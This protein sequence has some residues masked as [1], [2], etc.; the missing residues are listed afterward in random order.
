[1]I[2]GMPGLRLYGLRAADVGGWE[3][4]HV[5]VPHDRRRNAHHFAV[6]ERCRRPPEAVALKDI[7]VAPVA[8]CV[9]D[10][11]R[12]V[13]EPDVVRELVAETIQRGMCSVADLIREIH[14]S[15]RQRTALTR[16]ALAQID[17][18]VRSVAEARIRRAVLASDLPVPLFNP[19]LFTPDGEFIASPDGYFVNCAA[20]WEVDS[21]AYHLS[22]GSYLRT[23]R[24]Q[25]QV[26]TYGVILIAVSPVDA[27]SDQDAFIAELRG[28]VE[29]ASRREIPDIVVRAPLTAA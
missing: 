22:R 6:I 18:G 19:R 9:V 4:P 14:R 12:R 13:S 24:R 1:M 29:M 25:R 15:A 5:L 10:A 21:F 2:T 20:G 8:K 3:V 17:A 11:A 27:A 7:P 23:Q 26:T 28:L 16:A